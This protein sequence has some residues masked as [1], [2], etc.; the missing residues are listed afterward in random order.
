MSTEGERSLEEAGA[1]RTYSYWWD[2]T[3]RGLGET[4]M[5]W[6]RL[7]GLEHPFEE[8]DRPREIWDGAT[9]RENV[10][11]NNPDLMWN[12]VPMFNSPVE[13]TEVVILLS[14][15][16][17]TKRLGKD[18]SSPVVTHVQLCSKLFIPH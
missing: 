8:T 12:D 5:L 18:M 6:D 2:P 10:I 1:S 14:P 9:L 11:M 13:S 4:P 17:E 15:P 3:R 7:C 16:Q